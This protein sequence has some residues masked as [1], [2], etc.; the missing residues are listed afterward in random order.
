M[1]PDSHAKRASRWFVLYLGAAAAC[2]AG[3][4]PGKTPEEKRAERL[5]EQ[6][7]AHNSASRLSAAE[8]LGRMRWKDAVDPL[9][10]ASHDIREDVRLA[11]VVALG[12]VGD[13]RA[14]PPLIGALRSEGWALRKAAAEALGKIADPGSIAPLL[15][16]LDDKDRSVAMAA[17]A[18]LA[19][20]G[21]PAAEVLLK[22]LAGDKARTKEAAAYGLGLL[23]D[24][25][26]L[27]PLRAA[28]ADAEPLVR[29]A[30]AN[31]LSRMG[32]PESIAGIVALLRQQDKTLRT[33]AGKALVLYGNLAVPPL[34]EAA[35]DP[36]PDV[37]AAAVKLLHEIDDPRGMEPILAA[38]DDR[39]VK[40]AV[41]A[42]DLFYEKHS[43][44]PLT[45]VQ[46]QGLVLASRSQSDGVRR[47][48]AQLLL[49]TKGQGVF[50]ALVERLNDTQ[51]QV[52]LAAVE[53]LRALGDRRCVE[54][55]AGRLGDAELSVRVAAGS[56]LSAMGD[57]RGVDAMLVLLADPPEIESPKG[58]K[59]PEDQP[60]LLAIEALGQSGD[61]RAVEP[62]IALVKEHHRV[63][64]ALREQ[65][66]KLRE[67]K[68]KPP[69]SGPTVAAL[70]GEYRS[71]LPILTKAARALGRLG[72]PRAFDVL[73]PLLA[74]TTYYGWNPQQVRGASI[75]AMAQVDPK[76]ALTPILND[77]NRKGWR[78]PL[79][80]PVL[81]RALGDIGDPAGVDA[82]IDSLKWDVR[83]YRMT[84]ATSLVK[85]GPP[86]WPG[87]IARLNDPDKHIRAGVALVFSRM[88]DAAI[89]PLSQALKA[90]SPQTRQAAAWA[91]GEMQEK[92]AVEPLI[93][94]LK[95]GDL[96]VRGAAAWAL[97][98]LGDARAV[99]PVA[100]LLKDPQT[101]VR[102]GAA[103]ALGRIGHKDAV[104]PLIEALADAEPLL[105]IAVANALGGLGDERAIE[106][107]LAIIGTE[108]SVAVVSAA[109]SAIAAISPEAA[110]RFFAPQQK[111]KQQPRRWP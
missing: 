26:A 92:R 22:A 32:D 86:A 105:R 107:L 67:Q 98:R 42:S 72:D 35:A 57:K 21:Q 106:P 14:V 108:A 63:A 99:G 49:S 9:I 74:T 36:D 3:C 13:P 39:S 60:I 1:I 16:I 23:G 87:M 6:I 10:H 56:A 95:D 77:L 55:L 31:A 4:G 104:G 79:V 80:L 96:A 69:P 58:G 11:A 2:L 102:H 38:L 52:R 37:R 18:T 24:K 83:E 89:Q 5:I 33:G 97:G 34:C 94:A 29:L 111:A 73:E 50:E 47:R 82:L 109:K 100:A 76:R 62:L 7:K 48:A 17:G 25:R 61:R 84:A 41:V 88:G 91:L 53:A 45:S 64:A 15:V 103:E 43:R 101:R 30:A 27:E 59:K 65:I 81:M 51:W 20:I 71:H 66:D 75:V 68:E 40:V 85:I 54:G 8:E 70:E 93:A 90:P 19:R 110:Q 78:G 44:K 46:V 12:E 28:L